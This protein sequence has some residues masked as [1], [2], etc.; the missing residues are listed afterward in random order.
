MYLLNLRQ[1]NN[2]LNLIKYEEGM[3]KAYASKIGNYLDKETKVQNIAGTRD[4][5][6]VFDWWRIPTGMC[7]NSKIYKYAE[8][9]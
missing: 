8:K 4:S 5:Q 6:D 2:G 9:V 1:M 7:E 3:A